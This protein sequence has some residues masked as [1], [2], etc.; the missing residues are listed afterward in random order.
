MHNVATN[1]TRVNLH[2]IA[3]DLAIS[4]ATIGPYR[5]VQLLGLRYTRRGRSAL[6]QCPWH[7]DSSPSCSISIGRLGTIR[8]HCFSCSRSW[9]AHALVAKV[10]GLDTRSQWRDVLRRGA[11]LLSRHDILSALDGNDSSYSPPPPPPPPAPPPPPT[12]PPQSDIDDLLAACLR[13]DQDPVVSTYLRSRALDPLRVALL[14]LALALPPSPRNVP[15]WAL[16]WPRTG[17][18]LIFP[19]YDHRGAIASVRAVRVTPGDSPKRLSPAG[20]STRSTVLADALARELLRRS[21]WPSDWTPKRPRAII[22]EGETD[23]LTM[24]T[25]YAPGNDPEV[26]TLG[27]YAGGWTQDIADRFPTDIDVRVLTD[28]DPAGHRY[29]QSIHSTL[30]CRSTFVRVGAAP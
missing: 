17:H 9:D 12:Y 20:F 28:D 4:Y 16:P 25:Q 22:T 21:S 14:D 10:Q 27:I 11:E 19:S 30:H 6:I 1:Q 15:S 26:A 3:H 7:D 23:F 5:L 8:V 29:F 18:R 24:A 2:D 13:V